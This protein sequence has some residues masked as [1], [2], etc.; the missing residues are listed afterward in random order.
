VALHN[1]SNLDAPY[2]FLTF[3]V[4]EMGINEEV[5]ELYYHKFASN[6]TGQPP[7]GALSQLSWKEVASK[8]NT[9]GYIRVP[10]YLTNQQASGYTAFRRQGRRQC[11]PRAYI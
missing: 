4:P 11:G 5:Y 8:V 6:V 3:G 9:D 10:V 2:V 1:T 7:S